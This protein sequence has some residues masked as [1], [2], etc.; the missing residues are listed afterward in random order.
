[1]RLV[2]QPDNTQD[3]DKKWIPNP[4]F[5]SLHDNFGRVNVQVLELVEDG[6]SY[7]AG[8][9]YVY[10]GRGGIKVHETPKGVRKQLQKIALNMG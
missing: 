8:D 1:L 4:F 5:R 2:A 6:L 10:S 3:K 9:F 7:S